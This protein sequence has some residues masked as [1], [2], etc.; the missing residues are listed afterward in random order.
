MH[1]HQVAVRGLIAGASRTSLRRDSPIPVLSGVLGDFLEQLVG[2]AS[3]GSY[4]EHGIHDDLAVK[5]E[6]SLMRGAVR[7]EHSQIDYPAFVYRPSGWRRDLPLMN[8]SSMVSE[9][10]PVV[11]YLRHVGRSGRYAY[12]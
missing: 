9:L 4:R 2:L 5:L 1:A 7:V 6:Q 10:A 11:L 12:H 8:A 3:N